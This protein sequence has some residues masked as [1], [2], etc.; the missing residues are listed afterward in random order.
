VGSH[1][2]DKLLFSH[3]AA[4]RAGAIASDQI[5]RLEPLKQLELLEPLSFVKRLER[6]AAVQRL[7]RLEPNSFPL[8]LNV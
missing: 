6:S 7:E 2:G 4:D 3:F 1:K 5:E 8:T